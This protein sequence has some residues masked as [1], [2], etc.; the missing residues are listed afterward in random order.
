VFLGYSADR[1]QLSLIF[2]SMYP[3]ALL[4]W[5]AVALSWVLPAT[6]LFDATART[7]VAAYYVNPQYEKLKPHRTC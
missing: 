5:G 7:N 4:A 1:Q 2:F 3:K 6:A